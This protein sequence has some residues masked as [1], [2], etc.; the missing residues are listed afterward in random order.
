VSCGDGV[1]SAE[2]NPQWR[3]DARVSALAFAVLIAGVVFALSY[4][5]GGRSTALTSHAYDANGL[6]SSITD[7]NLRALVTNHYTSGRAAC[8]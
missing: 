2:H 3:N 4:I 1:K 6:L 7:Q 8:T 5:I